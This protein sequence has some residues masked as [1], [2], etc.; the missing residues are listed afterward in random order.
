LELGTIDAKLHPAQSPKRTDYTHP[1][2]VQTNNSRNRKMFHEVPQK[3]QTTSPFHI[4][5]CGEHSSKCGGRMKTYNIILF[6]SVSPLVNI[7]FKT[8]DPMKI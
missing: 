5:T 1:T 8:S 2:L 6:Q 3:R 7:P 4:V